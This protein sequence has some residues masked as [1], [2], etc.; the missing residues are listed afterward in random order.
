MKTPFFGPKWGSLFGHFG[1]SD[2]SGR[3]FTDHHTLRMEPAGQRPIVELRYNERWGPRSGDTMKNPHFW[4]KMGLVVW[5]LRII[6]YR[7]QAHRP[8]NTTYGA[9]RPNGNCL[10]AIQSVLGGKKWRYHEKNPYF[11]PKMGLVVCTLR[12]IGYRWQDHR[13]YKTMHGA[14]RPKG[15]HLAETQ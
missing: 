5:T 13:P 6:G 3:I 2:M 10:A 11:G 15:N 1:S 7:R 9:C 8:S 4:A 14:C 12:V